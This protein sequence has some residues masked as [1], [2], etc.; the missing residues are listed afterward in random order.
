MRT[1]T[2]IVSCTVAVLV[3]VAV[4]PTAQTE[5]QG[6]T[7]PP[8][9]ASSVAATS[10]V[11][12]RVTSVTGGIVR[13]AEIRA[14][15]VNGRETRLVTSDD[16]G[17]YEIRDL[18]A[19]SWNLTASK[20]GFVTQQYGQK[21]PFAAAEPLNVGERQ[22]VQANF[23]LGRAGAISGR[24]LDEFGDPVAGARV[25]V[26]RSRFTRGRRTLAPTGVGDQTDDT[27][28]FRLYALPPGDYYVGAALRA[29]TSE[30]PLAEAQIGAQTYYPGTPNLAEAQ[31]IRLGVGEEQPNLTFSLSP[32]RA[33]RVSGMVLSARGGPAEDASVRLVNASDFSLVGVPLGNFGMSQANGAFTI[34]NVVP[35]S[36]ILEAHAGSVF[37]GLTDGAE[38]ASLPVSIGPE[39]VTGLTITT[40]PGGA[41]AGVVTTE[42]GAPPPDG[43]QIRFEATTGGM[44]FESTVEGRSRPG[45]PGRGGALPPYS[46]RLPV[47]SGG[48]HLGVTVPQGW[49]LKTIEIG[50][51]DMTDKPIEVRGGNT[52][53][54]VVLTD[55]VTQLDGSVTSGTRPAPAVDV[56][57]FPDE[58]TLWAFPAR[59]VRVVKSGADGTFT[60]RG[61]PPHQSYLA[62][63]LDYL[64]EGETQD[65]EFL[66]GLRDQAS[67]FSIDYAESRN[68][69]LRVVTRP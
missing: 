50:G 45:G 2:V 56:V 24:V 3:A 39:D 55:R 64:D 31:R 48:F 42:S 29:A 46:F 61:I 32:V 35:G 14:R 30:T 47:T 69:A 57:V 7:R 5:G 13:G 40:A 34:T 38:N 44:E 67:R 62:V 9:F 52:D 28:A 58:P 19:G 60:V 65:P 53:A 43:V 20:T 63:A 1:G 15:E 41:I 68:V 16:S 12:G 66:E 54:R 6:G 49:M 17:A 59:H 4:R 51:S 26:L 25:Q 37:G 8:R 27:G 11:R 33:V 18:V 10:V 36:Y 23:T 21:R 22:A